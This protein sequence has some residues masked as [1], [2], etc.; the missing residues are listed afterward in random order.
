MEWTEEEGRGETSTPGPRISGGA[1]DQPHP[2][3][4][5]HGALGRRWKRAGERSRRQDCLDGP[6]RDEQ[7][8]CRLCGRALIGL[9]D[10][11]EPL[12]PRRCKITIGWSCFT[13]RHWQRG[14]QRRRQLSTFRGA[15]LAL[16][17]GVVLST[18]LPKYSTPRA[19]PQ[20]S[21]NLQAI[22]SCR[23][24][25]SRLVAPMRSPSTKGSPRT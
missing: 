13:S 2:P 1:S 11:T 14:T 15:L 21:P 17:C 16:P 3:A 19:T 23:R 4:P 20:S 12:T 10:W 7:W 25:L 22:F 9:A 5:A 6:A 18:E 24:S 8:V